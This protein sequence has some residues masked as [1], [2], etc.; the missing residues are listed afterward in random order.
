[1][2][3]LTWNIRWC[4]GTDGRVDPA[5]IARE[6]Q[7]IAAPDIACF[8]EAAAHFPELAGSGGEDQAAALAD[9]FPGYACAAGWALDLEGGAARRRYG[10]LIL[11]RWP[12]RAVRRHALP[13]PPDPGVPSM[14][15]AALEAEIDAPAGPLRVTCTHLEYYSSAQRAA[16]IERLRELHAE[17]CVH[18]SLGAARA[19]GSPLF[20]QPARPAPAI[21]CG[22][23]NL[24]P[25][26]ALH[27]RLAAP[28]G[29]GV[30]R[31]VD[32]WHCAHPGAPHVPTFRLGE[33]R[34]G[35]APYCC[36]YVFVSED[37]A[38]RIVEARVDS[39]TRASDHQ[40]L[41]V[42]LA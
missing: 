33:P 35:V 21:V 32:A 39:V 30:P 6:A 4:C 23:F 41:V 34:A 2:R 5:R 29:A 24:P 25:D 20:E 18:A 40:P 11:S 16:Q 7:R 15:R 8:Q 13:W 38:P 3:V 31:L 28:L 9:A 37:L 27:A 42:T 14:P 22:D 19:E 10:N 1:M 26:D 12:I 36:D 17:A